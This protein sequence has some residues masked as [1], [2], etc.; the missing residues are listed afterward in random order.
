MTQDRRRVPEEHEPN[1]SG[2][3]GDPGYDPFAD[4][5]IPEGWL[6]DVDPAAFVVPAR[7]PRKPKAEKTTAEIVQ[8]SFDDNAIAA[9]HEIVDIALGD[10]SS[11]RR[12][13][14]CKY[15]VD[16]VCGPVSAGAPMTAAEGPLAAL[17]GIF[18]EPTAEERQ[19]G[20]KV[21]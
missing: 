20:G 8:Q 4:I 15:I 7:E 16:R 19:R 9:A 12:L 5:E 6:D 11:A 18:R 1:S 17:A 14:A 10:P 13:S 2:K 21:Q 3:P